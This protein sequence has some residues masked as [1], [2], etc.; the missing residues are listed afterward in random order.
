MKDKEQMEGLRLIR[1]GAKLILKGLADYIGIDPEDQNFK[2]TP[3][4]VMRAY[5]E[6]F[7]GGKDTDK[8]IDEILKTGFPGEG[9]NEMIICKGIKTFSMCPHHLLPVECIID[10]GYIPGEHGKVLG[11]SKI[12]RIAQI[13]SKRPVLQEALTKDIG[14]AIEKTGPDGVAVRIRGIHY[15]MK[16]RGVKVEGETVTSYVSG[17]FMDKEATRNEF[18][19]LVAT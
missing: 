5:E 11:L 4:R 18:M 3:D 13:L 19:N 16:M 7:E 1:E 15:C 6:I 10:I 17:A 14:E 2:E 9:Y 12:P 8:Q